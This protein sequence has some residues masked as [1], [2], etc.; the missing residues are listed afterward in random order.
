VSLTSWKKRRKLRR[1]SEFFLKKDEVTA[2]K[3]KCSEAVG[4]DI[5]TSDT[6][7]KKKECLFN[8]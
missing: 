4:C 2:S 1:R 8:A 3:I 7:P 6:F 5:K